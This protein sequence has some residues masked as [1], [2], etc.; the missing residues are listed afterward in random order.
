[1][2]L[3]TSQ[4]VQWLRLHASTAEGLGSIPGQGTKIPHAVWYGQKETLKD[5]G[6]GLPLAAVA[7]AFLIVGYPDCRNGGWTE[8]NSLLT[9]DK[10]A[11]FL[12][13]QF[14]M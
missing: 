2:A 6:G 12:K 1:M 4:V 9:T 5:V 3:G 10:S 14:C 11:A 8:T 7:N 13:A